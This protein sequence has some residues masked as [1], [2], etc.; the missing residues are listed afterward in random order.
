M[1]GSA[2]VLLCLILGETIQEQI[3]TYT[4][5]EKERDCVREGEREG[6][7][8]RERERERESAQKYFKTVSV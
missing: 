4:V 3:C 6:E 5:G 2:Y 1:H 8:E 7:R